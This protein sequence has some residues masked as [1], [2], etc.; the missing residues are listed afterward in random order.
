[1]N[2][3]QIY[4][5]KGLRNWRLRLVAANGR[6]IADSEGYYSKWGAKRAARRTFPGSPIKETPE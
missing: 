5:G 6:I 1:M 4:R 2:T 3:V